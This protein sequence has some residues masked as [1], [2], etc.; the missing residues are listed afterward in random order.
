MFEAK[1]VEEIKA[2][3]LCSI[4]LFRKSYRIGDKLENYC[5]DGEAT[6]DN[7]WAFH[8]VLRDYKNLL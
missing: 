4:P 6:D 2:H 8:N 5:R 1:A 7:T 3:I